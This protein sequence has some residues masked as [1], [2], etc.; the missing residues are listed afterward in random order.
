MKLLPF[1]Y[2]AI[3][4]LGFTSCTWE[5]V[6]EPQAPNQRATQTQSQPK[7]VIQPTFRTSKCIIQEI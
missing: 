2:L 7:V 4:V 5:G 1:F 3:A 6:V